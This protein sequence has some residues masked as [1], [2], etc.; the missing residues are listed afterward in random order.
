VVAAPSSLTALDAVLAVATPL[1]AD[2]ELIVA[3][4]VAPGELREVAATLAA[5]REA[6]LAEQ[7]T[8][9]T[10]AFASPTPAL[11]LARIAA[12]ESAELLLT[13][14]DGPELDTEL[15]D[16]VPCDVALIA[17]GGG[18]PHAGPVVVAFGAG[19][20]DWSALNL[21]ATLARATGASLQLLGAA[22][23]HRGDG[24]DASRLL[25]DASLILQRTT[26]I[27]AEPLLVAPG[28]RGV[29][30]SAR[31][32]GL[33]VMGLSDR[34]RTEGLGRLRREILEAPPAPTLF[35]RRGPRRS[36][37]APPETMTRF[38]WSLTASPS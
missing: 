29:I 10:A 22:A 15:L 2:H 27:A 38:G 9:R 32:A 13:D 5:R 24:R 19:W 18:T 31:D 3:V 12:R 4:V 28:S 17:R 34:W 16:Q 6:L 26:G 7:L 21:A 11:D 14:I 23:N 1:A 20:H 8:V 36:A 33:L 35:V 25:A 30:A 37:L